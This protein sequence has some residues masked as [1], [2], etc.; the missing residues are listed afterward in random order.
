MKQKFTLFMPLAHSCDSHVE[1][2]HKTAFN[3]TERHDLKSELKAQE[4]VQKCS[5][6]ARP[7]PDDPC[8]HFASMSKGQC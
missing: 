5:P 8:C 2:P 3:S 6:S 7:Q 1:E 4:T